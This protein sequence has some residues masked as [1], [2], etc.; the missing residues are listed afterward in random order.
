MVI[1]I[2]YQPGEIAGE[3]LVGDNTINSILKI[4]NQ[5]IQNL[6]EKIKN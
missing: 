4:Q 6:F 2:G 1:S 3:N 5:F